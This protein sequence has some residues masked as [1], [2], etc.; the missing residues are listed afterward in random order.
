MSYFK[1]FG[2]I[3]YNGTQARNIL[4]AV[5]PSRL[6]IDKSFVYQKYMIKSGDSPESLADT[7]YQDANLYWVFLVVNNIINPMTGWPIDDAVFDEFVTK[8]YGNP[9]GIHHFIDNR[10]NRLC[11]DVDD[12]AYRA[13]PV[14]TLPFY[15]VPITNQ[16]HEQALN[17]EK[18]EIV[19][20]NPRYVNQFVETYNRAVEGKL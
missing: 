4:T 20:I 12:A 8:K 1:K 11:D 10:I 9:D 6:N 2:T 3:S 18:R 15:I 14:N 7:L 17:D 19:V 13:V 16:A 5:L